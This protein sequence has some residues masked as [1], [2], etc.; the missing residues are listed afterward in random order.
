MLKSRKA[1]KSDLKM[2]NQILKDANLPFEDCSQHIENFFVIENNE[3]IV[4]IAGLEIYA[5][6]ALLRSVVVTSNYRG[7]GIG[8]KI[9]EVMKNNALNLGIHT[10][11]LLTE[12][13]SGY[14]IKLD[15]KRKSRNDVPLAIQKSTQFSK[16]CPS[17]AIV[18]YLDISKS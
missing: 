13:A 14:F 17:S 2:V 6:I 1:N 4:A 8:K 18:M 10:L 11:Y 15:F 12:S 7:Q 16:L 5:K 3:K 9:V